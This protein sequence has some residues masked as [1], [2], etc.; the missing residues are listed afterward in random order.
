MKINEDKHWIEVESDDDYNPF[1]FRI[2]KMKNSQILLQTENGSA[3][4]SVDFE[5]LVAIRNMLNSV[6]ENIKQ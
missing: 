4:V 6:I 3:Y 5:E 2:H 1:R